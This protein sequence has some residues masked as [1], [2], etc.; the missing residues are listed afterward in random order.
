MW[1]SAWRSCGACGRWRTENRKLKQLV[2][3]LSLGGLLVTRGEE[4]MSYLGADGRTIHIPAQAR[5]VF[6]VTGAGD[7][8]IATIGCAL[9]VGGDLEDTLRLSNVAAGIV[10][11]KLGAETATPDEIRHELAIQEV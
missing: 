4:G 8:V 9:A 3:D 11:G 10:V 7:T 2:A 1:G 5:E 6:D